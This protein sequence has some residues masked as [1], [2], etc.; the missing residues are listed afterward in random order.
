M[1]VVQQSV[2][3]VLDDLKGDGL[4]DFDKIGTSNYFWSFPSAAGAIK[5]SKLEK[6][7]AELQALTTRL[8]ELEAAYST[9]L[10]GR[11]DNPERADLLA[12]LA[13]LITTST[14]LKAELEAYGAADPIKMETKRQAIELAKEACVLWTGTCDQ[15]GFSRRF[16]WESI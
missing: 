14:Q 5:K 9:E 8:E 2:K 10:C 16:N 3:D 1:P 4:V 13:S 7:Q 12:Q 15:N 6:D 11:E